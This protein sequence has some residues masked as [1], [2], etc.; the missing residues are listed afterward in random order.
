MIIILLLLYAFAPLPFEITDNFLSYLIPFI[1]ATLGLIISVWNFRNIRNLTGINL[2]TA[3]FFNWTIIVI[4]SLIFL[5]DF[6]IPVDRGLRNKNW[7]DM[8]MYIN[9]SDNNEQYVSQHIE[10]SGSD[11]PG[12]FVQVKPINRWLRWRFYSDEKKLK[13]GSW[14]FIDNRGNNN[15]PPFNLNETHIIFEEQKSKAKTVR[16]INGEQI[17]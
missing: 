4:Y 3:K 13:D 9:P 15:S 14:L 11:M 6:P 7:T 5:C 12:Q 16:I 17:D 8:V 10:I 2:K 1:I